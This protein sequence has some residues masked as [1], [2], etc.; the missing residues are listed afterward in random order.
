MEYIRLMS[1]LFFLRQP[2]HMHGFKQ[3]YACVRKYSSMPN[4]HINFDDLSRISSRHGYRPQ[5][6]VG[7]LF[8][9]IL[10]RF[11]T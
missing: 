9:S 5:Q 7:S 8:L 10:V 4:S 3:M 11:R 1:I 6:P 2:V